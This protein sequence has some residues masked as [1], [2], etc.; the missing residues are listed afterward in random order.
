M[1]NIFFLLLAASFFLGACKDDD[2]TSA[3]Y[4]EALEQDTVLLGAGEGEQTVTLNTNLFVTPELDNAGA[5]WC[6]V[7]FRPIPP[8]LLIRVQ[9]NPNGEI[10]STS[11]RLKTDLLQRTLCVRQLGQN[12]AIVLSPDSYKVPQAAS[13]LKVPFVANVDIQVNPLAKWITYKEMISGNQ[14]DTLVFDI[15]ATVEVSR[16]ADVELTYGTEVK[17]L[18]HIVQ[19]AED[20][21]Y[22]PVEPEGLVK[23]VE[24]AEVTAPDDVQ[25]LGGELK[26]MIDGNTE[27]GWS[28]YSEQAA[29]SLI[30]NFQDVEQV[31]YIIYQADAKYYAPVKKV[32][33]YV[34]RKGETGFTKYGTTYNV[35][36]EYGS[37][38]KIP[39]HEPILQPQA[40][41]MDITGYEVGN[42]QYGQCAEM[43]FYAFNV[44]TGSVFTDKTCSALQETVTIEQ[45]Q[46]MENTFLRNLAMHLYSGTYDTEFRVQEYTAYMNPDLQ[47]QKTKTSSFS[48]LEDP[49]GISVKAGEEIVVLVGDTHGEQIG[50]MLMDWE[51]M[52]YPKM[53]AEPKYTL[54]EGMNVFTADRNGLLYI[55][56]MVND[57]TG[58]QPVKI[59]IPTGEVNGYFNIDRH[60]NSQWKQL[61]QT[62]AKHKFL[63]VQG[64]LTHLLFPSDD[65]RALCPDDVVR[66][67]ELTDSIAFLE[68][69]LAGLYKYNRDNMNRMFCRIT[70]ETGDFAAF[71]TAY[72]TAYIPGEVKIICDADRLR[73]EPWAMAHEFG[74]CHQIESFKWK[75]MTEVSNN[76]FSLYVQTTFGNESRILA[77][78]CYPQA[79]DE[80]AVTGISHSACT[81]VFLT[82]V[83]FWQLQLYFDKV[84][85]QPD[86]YKDM[87]EEFRTNEVYGGNGE[88]QL[89][90]VKQAC[91][92][93]KKDL[94]KFFEYWGL[95][96]EDDLQPFP[97]GQRGQFAVTADGIAQTKGDIVAMGLGKALAI[98]YLKDDNVELFRQNKAVKAGQVTLNGTSLTLTGW[99]NVVAYEVY[100]SGK[101]IQVSQKPAFTLLSADVTVKAVAADGTLT[102]VQF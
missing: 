98:Q 69:D 25:M 13:V 97:G 62:K 18:L 47:R 102:D 79:H 57:V 3:D 31:D 66:L 41:R 45:I 28:G 95:L 91:K 86:F 34:Q 49:T 101:L 75:G 42:K 33:L 84:L 54:E 1:R 94:T 15:A 71:A 5:E 2:V 8:R 36:A 93:G 80:I 27:T 82:L 44:A 88:K 55:Y 40:I 17:T 9:P 43:E 35:N 96:T 4:F 67:L 52:T 90:F 61:L 100:Q 74:H 10:R 77:E 53:R 76:V 73:K 23:K 60:T 92:Y 83:P 29:L 78:G 7:E 16:R 63:D 58:K 32:D 81:N 51:N 68:H 65:F 19:Q 26:D 21:T 22:V 39:C 48:Y 89:N 72:H 24:V 11:I 56:Y 30:F 38:V 85:N 99:E 59:H 46:A 87:Y 14:A 20:T 64:K 12:P 37:V 6:E 70:Y 50:M